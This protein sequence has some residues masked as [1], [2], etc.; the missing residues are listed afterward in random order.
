VVITPAA[1]FVSAKGAM[2]IGVLAGVVPY[3]ACTKLKQIF[4]Y[5]DA[6]DTFGVH[7]VGGTLGA[8][9]TGILAT[10]DVNANLTDANSYAKANKL[11]ELVGNGLWVEQVKAM[12]LTIILAVVATAVIAY[13]VKAVVGL[14][15][16]EEV[17]T[18]GLDLAE[19]GEEGYHG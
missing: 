1:G 4:K 7:A 18:V 16:T 8:L 6:L 3:L 14:R 12:V 19:H 13:I 2:I 5:D 17:E 9:V 10:K 15:P 11:F